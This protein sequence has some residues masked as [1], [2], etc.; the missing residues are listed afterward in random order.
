MTDLS[1]NVAGI[2]F[3]NPIIPASGVF[4]YG[5][6]YEELF[7][8]SKLGGIA[9]KGTTITPRLGNP[10]PRIAETPSGMLNSVGLQNPGIDVFIERELPNLL[11][12]D[13]VILANIAG[14]TVDECVSIA[15]KL[16]NTDVHMIE[17]N[18][19]CP[20][21][22]KGG[23]AFGVHCDS[24]ANITSEVRKATKKPLVV[25]LS[26]NVTDITEIARAVEASGADAVSL[27]NTLLGMR[28]DIR[29]HRPILKNNV[30]GMSGPAVFPLAV[31][32]V[33]Q[34]S[35][36]ISIPIIGMGGVDSG[37]SAIE[38]MM[39]GA[40]AVQ[41]GAAIFTDPLAPVHIIDEMNEFLE[42]NNISDV[43]S[44]IGSVQPW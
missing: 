24:A 29:T 39:A 15:E 38:M 6:E 42:E 1:V 14:S 7:P 17:L 22:K 3:K 32:M 36:A 11:E 21:V 16:D 35:Q 18:I 20:N 2:D 9:T 19:S 12:K 10:S 43:K 4:G 44:I 28:I 41:V 37:K 5:R 40:S 23:A 25:K 8:L 33:W 26:P 27:I 31:R 13:T 34:V 30:G